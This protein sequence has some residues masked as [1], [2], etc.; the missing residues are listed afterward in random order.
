MSSRTRFRVDIALNKLDASS[1][2]TTC[3]REPWGPLVATL[4]H[5]RA[6]MQYNNEGVRARVSQPSFYN[7]LPVCSIR[8]FRTYLKENRQEL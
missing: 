3:F 1:M 7:S 5:T 4:L 8:T 2:E 6:C